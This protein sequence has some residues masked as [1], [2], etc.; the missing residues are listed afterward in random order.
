MNVFGVAR[1]ASCK[2]KE[3]ITRDRC[4]LLNSKFEIFVEFRIL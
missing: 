3:K 2:V 4:S 1:V